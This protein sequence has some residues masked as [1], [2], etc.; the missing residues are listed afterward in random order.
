M[1]FAYHDLLSL[2]CVSKPDLVNPSEKILFSAL[3][4]LRVL[5]H[6]E[7]MIEKAD[8]C[9][10]PFDGLEEHDPPLCQSLRDSTECF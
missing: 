1:L 3:S 8:C 4:H 2:K 7:L 6:P 5:A 9:L 10:S